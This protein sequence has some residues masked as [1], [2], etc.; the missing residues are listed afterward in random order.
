[1]EYIKL[2]ALQIDDF[3]SSIFFEDNYALKDIEIAKKDKADLEEKGYI[4]VLANTRSNIKITN[5][6]NTR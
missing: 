3:S 5:T 6:H 1:M 4:C 2:I